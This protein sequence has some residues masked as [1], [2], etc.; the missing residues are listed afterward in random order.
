MRVQSPQKTIEATERLAHHLVETFGKPAG[1]EF[2]LKVAWGGRGTIERL[3]AMAFE[4][5]ESPT[6]YFS[7]CA[8][9]AVA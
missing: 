9:R 7:K 6:R 2:Y 1:Y 5:G 4:K 3:V 8:R